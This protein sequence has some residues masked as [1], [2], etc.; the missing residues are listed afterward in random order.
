MANRIATI[1]DVAEKAGVSTSTVS[2]VLSGAETV[3][4]ISGDTRE[5]V[6]QAA[7]ELGYRPH[8]SARALSG[9]ATNLLGVIVRELGDPWFAQLIETISGAAR[10]HGYDLVLGNAKRDPEEALALRNMMLDL[11]YCDGLLL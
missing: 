6:Q 5:R 3:I 10:E 8:P 4:P 7:R 11:R 2:R 1:R 9:K